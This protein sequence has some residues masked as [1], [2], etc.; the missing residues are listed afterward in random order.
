MVATK[1]W[2]FQF[3]AKSRDWSPIFRYP[4][5]IGWSPVSMDSS[6]EKIFQYDPESFP[7]WTY[8]LCGTSSERVL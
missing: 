1:P 4:I 3:L 6:N 7:Y 8:P 5:S 2:I